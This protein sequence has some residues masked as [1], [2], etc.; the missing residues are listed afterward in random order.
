M[1]EEYD[2][3]PGI[4]PLVV[5]DHAFLTLLVNADGGHRWALNIPY[6]RDYVESADKNFVVTAGNS[7]VGMLVPRNKRTFRHFND[8]VVVRPWRESDPESYSLASNRRL[9]WE[10]TP[11]LLWQEYHETVI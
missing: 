5:S 1:S 9:H 3:I 10:M 2:I 11:V 6:H 8:T 4:G 7:D